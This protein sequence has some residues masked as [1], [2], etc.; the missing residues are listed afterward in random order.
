IFYLFYL[1]SRRQHTISKR[2]W[3]SDVYSSDLG[4]FHKI[5][6][7][8]PK[9]RRRYSER[10]RTNNKWYSSIHTLDGQLP[11]FKSDMSIR[12]STWEHFC[13]P[14]KCNYPDQGIDQIGESPF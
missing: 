14:H 3:S 5:N 1:S 10:G 2:D 12:F 8:G 4:C 7:K 11:F 9:Y 13:I 6:C